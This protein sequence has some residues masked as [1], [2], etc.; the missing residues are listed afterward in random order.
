MRKPEPIDNRTALPE[1]PK[2]FLDQFRVFIRSRGLAYTTE[3]TNLIW[4]KRFFRFSKYQSPKD[5][6]LQDID[7]FL[8]YLAQQRFCS[9]NTQATALNALIL[10]YREFLGFETCGL[11]FNYAKRKPKVPIV[12]SK[13]EAASVIQ[14]LSDVPKLVTQL[15]Y[16]SGLRISEAL[17]LRVKDIDFANGGLFVM[18]AKGDKSRRTLLPLSLHQSLQSQIA[19]VKHTFEADLAIGKAGV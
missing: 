8:N 19:F 14:E 10:L 13:A 15:M 2:G 11:G 12:L 6:R 16:G 17:N 7:T 4:A 5:F 1:M 18:E 9:P 3:K